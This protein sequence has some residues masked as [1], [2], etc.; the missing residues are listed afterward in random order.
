MSPRCYW[1]IIL[2]ASSFTSGA[3]ASVGIVNGVCTEDTVCPRSTTCQESSFH[4]G[5]ELRCLHK[6][7]VPLNGADWAAMSLLFVSCALAAGGGIG[8][9]GLLVS[10][11][12]SQ[13][14]PLLNPRRQQHTHAAKASRG[15]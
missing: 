5:N 4:N 10:R 14:L 12:P 7:L 11:S 2:A 1:I 15:S 13:T 9:G 8:G 6:P 3:V